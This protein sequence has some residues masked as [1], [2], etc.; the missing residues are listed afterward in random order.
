[1][2][3]Q[4]T[5]QDLPL[6]P[7]STLPPPA[8]PPNPSRCDRP[9]PPASR[10]EPRRP[11]D[12]RRTARERTRPRAGQHRAAVLEFIR[13]QGT[14]GATDHETA[15]QLGLL[16]DTARAR[17]VKLRDD[18]LVEDSGR[19]RL[20]PNKGK[21][22]VWVAVKGKAAAD[23][24]IA[25]TAEAE[26]RTAGCVGAGRAGVIGINDAGLM[27]RRERQGSCPWCGRSRH[28]VSVYGVATCENCHSPATESLVA[29]R[30]NGGEA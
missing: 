3:P 20:T 23:G 26:G 17:R 24:C 11:L 16:L 7:A 10:V 30:T 19:R 13:N 27:L 4:A 6:F 1:M 21:A 22:A 8:S 18:D 29:K 9:P 5:S 15:A 14:K 2:S 12:T 25:G 28:W